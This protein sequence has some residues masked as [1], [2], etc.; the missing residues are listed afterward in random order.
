MPWT[1]LGMVVVLGCA[2]LCWSAEPLSPYIGQEQR[3]IT[4]LSAEKV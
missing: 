4:A 3:E 2:G 1:G